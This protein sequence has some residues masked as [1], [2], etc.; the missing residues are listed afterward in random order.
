MDRPEDRGE[1]TGGAESSKPRAD[2]RHERQVQEL[3][4]EGD[5]AV[6]DCVESEQLETCEEKCPFGQ[7]PDGALRVGVKQRGEQ[8]AEAVYV[9]AEAEPREVVR[10][11]PGLEAAP[12]DEDTN[13]RR[14][15]PPGY[16]PGACHLASSPALRVTMPSSRT[17]PPPGAIDLSSRKLT[18]TGSAASR[19]A[20]TSR[21]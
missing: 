14:R 19:L 15:D 20:G 5:Q 3:R 16:A 8:I 7:R 4:A 10:A 12:P 1:E 17:S 9:L 6:W 21:L 18:R 2:C 13:E 11:K